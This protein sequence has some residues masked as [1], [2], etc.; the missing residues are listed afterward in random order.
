VVYSGVLEKGAPTQ[1]YQMTSEQSNRRPAKPLF[2][3]CL[4]LWLIQTLVLASGA[5]LLM[6]SDADWVDYFEHQR[7]VRHF[8][9]NPVEMV[10]VEALGT[11]C[12]LVGISGL[13]DNDGSTL[14]AVWAGYMPLFIGMCLILLFVR[15]LFHPWWLFGARG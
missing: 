3:C 1:G 11:L 12:I 4:V 2:R 6:Y 9:A 14:D 8:M 5:S 13:Q 7:L 15:S 10:I